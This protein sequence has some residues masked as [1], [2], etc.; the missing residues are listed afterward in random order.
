[1]QGGIISP[2]TMED[3]KAVLGMLDSY[4]GREETLAREA[5]IKEISYPNF[6]GMLKSELESWIETYNVLYPN[7]K[8]E[9]VGTLKQDL[10]NAIKTK[11]ALD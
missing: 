2:R 7:S 5:E 9:P 6:D 11:F 8:I 10:I 1:M 4:L 3:V